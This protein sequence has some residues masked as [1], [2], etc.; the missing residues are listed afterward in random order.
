MVTFLSFTLFSSFSGLAEATGDSLSILSISKDAASPAFV[1]SVNHAFIMQF[2]LTSNGP[3]YFCDC[4]SCP[5]FVIE[6]LISY[7]S[8][9]LSLIVTVTSFFVGFVGVGIISIFPSYVFLFLSKVF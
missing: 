2:S 3:V 7:P 5:F 4:P 9:K 1:P 8:F 6:Y